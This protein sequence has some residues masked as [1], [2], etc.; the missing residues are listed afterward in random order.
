V[1]AAEPS[2][3]GQCPVSLLPSRGF[4][5]NIHITHCTPVQKILLLNEK[6]AAS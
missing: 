1:D 4:L 3:L 2:A 6:N 5:R